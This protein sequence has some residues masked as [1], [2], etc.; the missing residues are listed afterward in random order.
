MYGQM[1]GEACDLR[2]GV[3]FDTVVERLAEAGG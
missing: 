3:T 1:V 2:N